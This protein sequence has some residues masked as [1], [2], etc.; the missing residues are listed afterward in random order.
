MYFF[1]TQDFAFPKGSATGSMQIFWEDTWYSHY[2]MNDYV[3]VNNPDGT[4]G[5][6]YDANQ[7]TGSTSGIQN[8]TSQVTQE[9]CKLLSDKFDETRNQIRDAFYSGYN[10]LPECYRPNV[11]YTCASERF[12]TFFQTYGLYKN[13]PNCYW[14]SVRNVCVTKRHPL[15]ETNNSFVIYDKNNG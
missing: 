2:Y 11:Q 1:D 3:F 14:D 10:Q 7:F 9:F 15:D 12:A 4:L 5:V 8:F 13:V 6:Y